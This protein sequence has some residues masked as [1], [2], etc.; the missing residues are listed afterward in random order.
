MIV[1]RVSLT[2]TG[3]VSAAALMAT[4]ASAAPAAFYLQEQ[5]T[6]GTGRAFSGEVADTGVQSL[7]WN[8]AAAA[9]GGHEAYLGSHGV[10]PSSDVDD[11]GSTITFP[12]P[13]AGLTVPVGGD[14]HADDPISSGYIPNLGFTTPVADR[15][16]V[17]VF[18]AAPFNLST[19]Y[20]RDSFARYEAIKSRLT[21]VNIQGGGAWRV[22][23]QFDVGLAFDMMLADARLTSAVPNLPPAATDGRNSLHGHGWDFGWNVGMQWHPMPNLDV[24]LSYRSKIDHEIDGAVEVSG[25]LGPLAAG[26]FAGPGKATFTTPWI[27]TLGARW[28]VIDRLT[29][30]AQ[31]QWVGWD[32]F[33]AIRIRTAAGRTTLPQNYNSE[34]SGAIGADYVLNPTWTVRAG[35]QFD[36][37]PTPDRGRTARV[38]DG[39]RWIFAA[40]AS[41]KAAEHLTVDASA[42]YVAFDD[43]RIDSTA[44]FFVGTPAQ[45]TVHQLGDVSGH[46][47]VISAGLHWVY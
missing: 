44:D 6:R 47:W 45:T 16:A 43:T 40:G 14:P 4:A 27:A 8:S 7:W 46:A 3:A 11:R 19:K 37:T 39:D 31:V 30:D 21:T 22:N 34:V 33:D 28:G 9:R 41:W 10:F 23:D 13:P 1:R 5:S 32:E 12:V 15:F 38:P 24:G 17:A 20:D 2:L 42:D 26:N 25:L 18:V 29:L 36:P 35:V